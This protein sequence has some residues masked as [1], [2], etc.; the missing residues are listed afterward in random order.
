[1]EMEE[2]LISVALSCGA[3]YVE[4]RDYH[5]YLHVISDGDKRTLI[6]TVAQSERDARMAIRETN[7]NVK[8]LFTISLF[9]L[10]E[11]TRRNESEE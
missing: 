6:T 11:L 5:I 7:R 8:I 10:L 9:D 3:W 1:M 2:D 4:P